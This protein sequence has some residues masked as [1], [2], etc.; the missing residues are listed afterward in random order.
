[1]GIFHKA[2]VF[3]FSSQ[4]KVSAGDYIQLG[5]NTTQNIKAK[6]LNFVHL[7]ILHY[8]KQNLQL[9]LAFFSQDKSFYL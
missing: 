2:T 6:H 3:G 9:H 1:M 5:L 8:S 4:R 7:I